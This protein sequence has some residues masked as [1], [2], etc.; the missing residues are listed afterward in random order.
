MGAVGCLESR[1]WKCRVPDVELH[2][3]Y[4]EK[5]KNPENKLNDWFIMLGESTYNQ[6]LIFRSWVIMK[7][8]CRLIKIKK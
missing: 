7:S 1:A 8:I 4:L 2:C 3:F 5:E 6:Q